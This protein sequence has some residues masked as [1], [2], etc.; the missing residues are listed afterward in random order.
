MH[1]YP[2]Y[3]HVTKLVNLI[4]PLLFIMFQFWIK[5]LY[6]ILDNKIHALEEI[7]Q[8]L[9]IFR[10]HKP[11]SNA[12][13]YTEMHLLQK[14]IFVLLWERNGFFTKIKISDKSEYPW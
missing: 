9:T 12:A 8:N 6:F 14:K 13:S 4:L 1:K 5:H 7:E 11:I 10:K 3:V 2:A